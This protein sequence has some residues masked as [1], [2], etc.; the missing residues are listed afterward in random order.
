MLLVCDTVVFVSGICLVV[1]LFVVVFAVIVSFFVIIIVIIIILV[2]PI[3]SPRAW[4]RWQT[5]LIDKQSQPD[6]KFKFIISTKNILKMPPS[7][8]V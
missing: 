1:V 2:K 4:N 8:E 6:G 7:K 5:D 3:L